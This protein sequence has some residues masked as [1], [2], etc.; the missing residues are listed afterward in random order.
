MTVGTGA[1]I[2]TPT[3]PFSEDEWALVNGW[4]DH[5][6]ADFTGKVVRTANLRAN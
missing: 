3:H 6:Y 2:F 4:L 5:I 1:T